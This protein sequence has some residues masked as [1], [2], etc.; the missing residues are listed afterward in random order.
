M[1]TL[2]RTAS[3]TL[4][5]LVGS[6]AL[7][8]DVQLRT[9]G[10]RRAA[11]RSIKVLDEKTRDG[12]RAYAE[13]VNA[14]VAEHALPSEY[15]LLG[16]TKLEPWQPV[17][18]VVIGK[19]LA[20]LLSFEDDIGPTLQFLEYQQKLSS[21]DPQ[22]GAAV[23]FLDAFRSA[24][25]SPATTVPDA[26]SLRTGAS[27]NQGNQG[28]ARG[29]M[30]PGHPGLDPAFI[31]LLKQ[32]QSK[33]ERVPLL[34]SAIAR[35]EHGI[36][37]NEW[38]VSGAYTR[39]GRALVAN[40]PHLSL[41]LPANFYDVHLVS[42]RDGLNTIGSAFPG[43]PWI[44]L[45]QNSFITWGST[46]T[47]FDV[48]DYYQEQV[49]ADPSSPSGLSSVYQGALEPIEALPV[50]FNVNLRDGVP[51]H[52]VPAPSGG[53]IPPVVLI[54]PRR[55][56]GP[57]L[58]LDRENGS[59]IS[60]QYT[61][62]S[63]TRDVDTLRLLNYARNQREFVNAL[64]FLDFGAENFVYGDV[65]GNIAYFASGEVPLREDLQTGTVQGSPPWFIRDGRGG[66]EWLRLEKPGR[67]DGTGYQYLPFEELPQVVNPRA[68]FV[69]NA[70]NDPAGVT[71]DNNPLNQ[72][73]PGHNG[74]FYLAY[75]FDYGSRAGRIT[76][77]LRERIAA[78]RPMDREDM[79]AIQADVVLFDAEVLK[80]YI[81]EAFNRA[82]RPEAPGAL[83]AL[84]ADPRVS[85]AV[86]RLRRWNHSTPTG[87]P[88][89][90]DA[91]IEGLGQEEGQRVSHS[92][93]ATLY[94]VWRG[95]MVANGLDRTLSGLGLS[96]PPSDEAIRAIAQL[97]ERNGIGQSSID[98]F[99]WT[100]LASAP[101][102]RDFAVLKSLQD[103]LNLL[104]GPAFAAA[105]NGS[106]NQD[107][108][109][110]GKLHRHTFN[111]LLGGPFD[112]P[113]ATPNFPPTFPTLPGL[114]IDGGFGTVDSASH[115][116]RANS[117]NEFVFATGPNRRY[118]G[119][120]G[121]RPGSIRGETSL[122]GGISGRLGDP[123]YANLLERY[124][125]NQTYPL[126]QGLFR[127]SPR[128]DDDV[129][130]ESQE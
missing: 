45:G 113:G 38:A 24:P 105:F 61:G 91:D 40:D 74:I 69:V 86:E 44:L 79:K 59:A 48:T 26:N 89:G 36:G 101:D 117:A 90:Y 3:G 93:A 43:V 21:I 92:I 125:R 9:I 14:W 129:R 127:H 7:A 82:R 96:T 16:L 103:A 94:S 20:F 8:S 128:A 13:G 62:F 51:D 5:E 111:S 12:M 19:L 56:N 119:S 50:T 112:I 4:A 39:D 18:T 75:T 17:D 28:A 33:V 72:L 22:L 55:N 81:I 30:T 10:L 100:G 60:L 53:D 110:W 29:A 23:F 120:V 108:Y 25:F 67:Y 1:D 77:L 15:G 46:V 31:K 99:A 27:V 37:S 68:G 57:V 63:A 118:V 114:A 95:Q 87:V 85:E 106:D 11:E 97:L 123:F 54:V 66:N 6:D 115:D 126:R 65:Q 49:V 70:N 116:I 71:L 34:K 122:P 124:L 109:R 78:N 104:A 76:E 84:A 47:G 32:Y 2:R 121:H 41:G 107:D 80:P 73:R 35:R 58:Q 52:I 98:Y 83:T 88:S 64:Q 42:L 102:R 130:A